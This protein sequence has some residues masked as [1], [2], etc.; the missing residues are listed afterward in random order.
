MIRADGDLALRSVDVRRFDATGVAVRR[1]FGEGWA[2]G[3]GMTMRAMTAGALMVLLLTGPAWAQRDLP[4][5]GLTPGAIN[6]AVTQGNIG[7]TIC[8]RGWTRTIRPPAQYTEDL[9]RRQIREY[10]LR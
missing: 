8:V 9:K 10:R 7:A 4:D 5:P 1:R 2:I 3:G 6:P